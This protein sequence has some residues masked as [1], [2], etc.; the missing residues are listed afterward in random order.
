MISACSDTSKTIPLAVNSCPPLPADLIAEANRA[1]PLPKDGDAARN[2][3]GDLVISEVR[4]N[5]ALK[6]GIKLYEGCRS[7]EN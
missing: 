6:R 4:K 5:K 1:T 2:F 7:G 3:A